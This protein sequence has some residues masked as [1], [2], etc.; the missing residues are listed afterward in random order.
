MTD[1]QDITLVVDGV[2]VLDKYNVRFV[3][4]AASAGIL[5]LMADPRWG[6]I[7]NRETVPPD[8][9]RPPEVRVDDLAAAY[10]RFEPDALYE[11][12]RAR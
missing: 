9:G 10:P 3:L 11:A 2:E 5:A 6:A 4:S 7:V 8:D 1:A 12:L